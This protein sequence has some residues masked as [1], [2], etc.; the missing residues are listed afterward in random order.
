M[1]LRIV[2]YGDPILTKKAEPVTEFNEELKQLV[3]DMF[4]TMYAAPGVGLAAPQVGISKRLFVMDCSSGKDPKQKIAFIN[5]EILS[6]EG[7]QIGDEGCLSFPGIYIEVRRPK[8]VIARAFDVEGKQFTIDAMDLAARCIAHETDH[9]DGELFINHLSPLKK[10]L[11][12]ARIK[13]L[14]KTGRW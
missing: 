1:K 5:P 8:R 4:E 6:T 2:K 7:E 13:K 14:I 12:K 3:A 9:L 11:I 10:E